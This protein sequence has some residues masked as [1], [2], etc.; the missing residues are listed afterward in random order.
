MNL[1]IEGIHTELDVKPD[2]KPEISMLDQY[3]ASLDIALD[4]TLEPPLDSTK[5]PTLD[6]VLDQLC[7]PDKSDVKVKVAI[8]KNFKC[9][10][11]HTKYKT[12]PGKQGDNI[13][14]CIDFAVCILG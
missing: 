1:H 14:F 12:R 6:S 11:C 5:E 8:I 10:Q 3:Y 4:P 9:L 13:F 2:I 7:S